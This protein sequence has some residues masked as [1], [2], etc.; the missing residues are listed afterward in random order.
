M[1]ADTDA[2]LGELGYGPTEIDRLRAE[3]VV[4]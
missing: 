4:A 2:V 1:G 3:G